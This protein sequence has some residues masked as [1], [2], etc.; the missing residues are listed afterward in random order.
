M[1]LGHAYRRRSAVIAAAITAAVALLAAH[2]ILAQPAPAQPGATALM[3]IATGILQPTPILA[4]RA[5]RATPGLAPQGANDF[6]C[7]SG[8][9][10]PVLLVHG[11]DASAYS[12]FAAL[13]P[14]LRLEGYCVFALNYGVGEP[15]LDLSPT[16][17]PGVPTYGTADIRLSAVEVADAVESIQRATG[18]RAV[19]LVG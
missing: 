19:S 18:A 11:T 5:D 6:A 9:R 12:D 16:S 17:A 3:P 14:R 7:H 1:G 13:A 15:G 10:P 8:D 4:K 2:S